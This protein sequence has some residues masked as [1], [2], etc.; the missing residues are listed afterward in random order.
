MCP[1]KHWALITDIFCQNKKQVANNRITKLKTQINKGGGGDQETNT[2]VNFS[3]D[4]MELRW[5]EE[6][7]GKKKTQKTSKTFTEIKLEAL[8]WGPEINDRSWSAP[9]W[10]LTK[11]VYANQH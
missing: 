10:W 9:S 5:G 4:D 2:N 11:R 1:A 8:K 7:R 6:R 3:D